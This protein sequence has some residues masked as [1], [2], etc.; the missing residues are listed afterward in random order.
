MSTLTLLLLVTI[1]VGPVSSADQGIT[2]DQ[3]LREL[4]AI[5]NV[6]QPS[7]ANLELL[8]GSLGAEDSRVRFAAVSTLS[9][10]IMRA[11]GP[12]LIESLRSR[13]V[14][15]Q[16]LVSLVADGDF[17]VRG[18]A[19]RA[20]EALGQAGKA[21]ILSSLIAAFDR[22]VESTVRAIFV[23]AIGKNGRSPAADEVILSGLTDASPLVRNGAAR[24]VAVRPLP[25]ALP[26]VI[27]E[28]QTMDEATRSDF[29]TAFVGFGAAAKPHVHV[30]ENLLAI[31]LRPDRAAQIRRAIQLVR[32]EQ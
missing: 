15:I 29:V 26:L 11:R 8:E 16:Q 5:G 6:P 23:S 17:R 12:A 7:E 14:L 25:V 30:L 4:A 22:E 28:L 19:V 3:R 13:E 24:V 2:P 1:G 21:P 18:A 20:L 9:I 10:L 32:G 31:E 27:Q